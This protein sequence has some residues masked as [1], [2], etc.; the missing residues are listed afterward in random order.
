MHRLLEKV[1]NELENIANKGLTS[2]NLEAAYKLIDIYKDIHEA[3]YY[4]TETEKEKEEG[5]YEARG[6]RGRYSEGD[7]DRYERGGR[8]GSS[9]SSNSYNARGSYNLYNIDDRTQRQMERMREGMEYYDEGRGRYRGGDSE[10]RMIDGIEMTMS[11]ICNF[12]ECL[13]DYAETSKE[14]EIIRKHIEKMKKL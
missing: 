12:V 1:E 13:Y 14:K 11:A 6:G 9:G 7:Y 8:G 3:K 4:K 2:S 5:R 10:E